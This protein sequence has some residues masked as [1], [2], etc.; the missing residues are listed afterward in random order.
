[1]FSCG[2]II[3]RGGGDL[4]TGVVQ[5]F[6]R[7]G[8]DVLVLEAPNPLAVRRTVALC[9]AVYDGTARVEDLNAVRIKT[10]DEAEGCWQQGQVPVLV[11]PEGRCIPA[12]RPD[13]VVDAI[14]AKHNL[15]THRGMAPITIGLGPGFEAGRDVDVVIET[16][17]GHDLGRLIFKG[18]ALPNT[19]TPGEIGGQSDLRVFHAPH[20][21]AVH[22]IKSIGDVAQAGEAVLTVDATPVCTRF[23]GL[24]R[25]MLR[26]GTQVAK[27][28]KIGDIDPRTDVDVHTISDKARCIGGGAL[29]AYLHLAQKRKRSM[30]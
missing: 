30:P 28:T 10:P 8:A 27:G 17:R 20:A 5:K 12:F 13:A 4:A 22:P 25:G 6:V 1:M 15:G 24:I 9:E 2:R 16:F 23:S 21:G 7:A 14:I 19:G 11:D 3:I 29:E 18:G 26:G